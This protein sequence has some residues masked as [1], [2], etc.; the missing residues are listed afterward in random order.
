MDRMD[1]VDRTDGNGEEKMTKK[2]T[3]HFTLEEMTFSATGVRHDVKNE[4]DAESLKNLKKL[5]TEILEP[6]RKMVGPLWIYSGFRCEKLNKLVGGS[7]KS[8][9]KKGQAADIVPLKTP[10]KKAYLALVKSKIPFDQA[11]FEFANWIHV[12]WSE[13]PRGQALVATKQNGKTVYA[14]LQAFGRGNS[15]GG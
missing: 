14:T 8:Q 5:C 11:I 3:E 10:L 9:H 7:P 2:L 6:F 1:G 4:P 13:K 15:R 12:S